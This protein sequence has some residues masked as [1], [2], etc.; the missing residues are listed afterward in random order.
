MFYH[1]RSRRALSCATSNPPVP[2]GQPTPPAN[3]SPTR[4]RRSIGDRRLAIGDWLAPRRFLSPPWVCV[5]TTIRLCWARISILELR[6]RW[7]CLASISRSTSRRYPMMCHCRIR[8]RSRRRTRTP[9]ALRA[10]ASVT[11]VR[12]RQVLCNV[13]AL[14]CGAHAPLLPPL[15][16][17]AW[18]FAIFS[19]NFTRGRPI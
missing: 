9:N 3:A 15:A 1:Q 11:T 14:C 12:A 17:S 4:P 10:A 7:R 2:T 13:I 8:A 6:V 16:P 19:C 18:A 5:H